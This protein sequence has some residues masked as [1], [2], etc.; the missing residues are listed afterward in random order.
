VSIDF[1]ADLAAMIE[2]FGESVTIAGV[3]KTGIV[4]LGGSLLF[5]GDGAAV[6]TGDPAIL[7]RVADYATV[8][9]NAAVTV[10]TVSYKVRDVEPYGVDGRAWLVRLKRAA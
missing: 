9:S 8:A 5:T 3:T 7:V 6:R 10:R 1:D 2:P 4:D